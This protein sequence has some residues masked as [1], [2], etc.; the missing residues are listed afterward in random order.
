[1]QRQP[2]APKQSSLAHRRQRHDG[3]PVVASVGVGP[4]AD[5][6]K[7]YNII[8]HVFFQPFEVLNFGAHSACR[9]PDP[10]SAIIRMIARSALRQVVLQHGAGH[11]AALSVP[12]EVGDGRGGV[13]DLTDDVVVRGGR[14]SH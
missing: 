6:D 10:S 2:Y 1:M 4:G 3:D 5:H 7:I 13:L 14:R 9:H 8:T 12:G 11:I